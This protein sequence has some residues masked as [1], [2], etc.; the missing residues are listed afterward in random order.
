MKKHLPLI[1]S[2]LLA[3]IYSCQSGPKQPPNIIL[4]FAD[5]QCYETVHAY[6]NQEII[7]PNLDALAR[8]G[9]TFSHAYNMGGWHGAVCV[10]SRTMLN[11]G[12]FL[13][14]AQPET[15]DR[16]NIDHW[17]EEGK[18]W[19][20]L[21]EQAGYDTYMTGKWHVGTPAGETFMTATDIR[22]GM[23][24]QTPEGY[25]RPVEGQEDLWSPYDT[26]FGGFWEGGTHWTKKLAN[27]AA[28]YIKTAAAKEKPFFM[29]LAF[30][31]AHDPR[32]APKEFID[33]YPLENISL[34]LN[35]LQ[36]YPYKDS[37]GCGPWLRDEKLAPFP[38]T[39]YAVKVNR[40]EYYALVT[41]MDEQIGRILEALEK[42]GE[43]DNTY[44]FFTADHGLGNGHHGLMGKQNMYDH[45]V[46]VPL[47]VCG[48]GIPKNKKLEMPVYLQ[49]IMPSTLEL[50]GVEIPGHVE[51]KS[52]LP[53]I[54][55]KKSTQ[56][57][58]IY[59]AYMDVQRMVAEDGFKLI[60]YPRVPV[61]RLYNLREDP[62]EMNDLAGD[63]A[64]RIK[65]KELF[66]TLQKLQEETGDTLD[67]GSLFPEMGD[68]KQ[69]K[70]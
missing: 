54:D 5:D 23:P 33:M 53:L 48:K 70:L 16:D 51:F 43:L 61:A 52:L 56:Y 66:N 20:Q 47:M 44:I 22:Q 25:N 67:L 2:L 30:N 32:Q 11:T 9:V 69:T 59:G 50:A 35:F 8:Q 6:G 4:I 41:Y 68:K 3:G 38:R 58:A 36:E 39:P 24:E 40:Q 62:D 46:R 27:T 60:L 7:T 21:M 18:M 34:P 31:A 13:W 14:H 37:M 64:N 1:F 55:G 65:M 28:S 10:A 26:T 12:R 63:P 45:S 15:G 19:A 49:D 42:S 57:D 29:Y 17:R